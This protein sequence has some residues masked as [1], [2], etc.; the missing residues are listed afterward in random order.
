MAKGCVT[1]INRAV[2]R[3]RN[4]RG[5]SCQ[6]SI[7]IASRKCAGHKVKKRKKGKRRKFRRAGAVGFYG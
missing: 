2:T 7:T 5:K 1:A 3:C 6:K 4:K